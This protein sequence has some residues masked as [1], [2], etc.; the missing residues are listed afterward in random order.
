[1]TTERQLQEGLQTQLQTLE[2]FAAAHVAIND[3]NLMDEGAS[4]RRIVII[5]NTDNFSALQA[6]GDRSFG[7]AVIPATMAVR[8]VDWKVSLDDFRDTR[9]AIVDLFN[10]TGGARSLGLSAV[11]VDSVT[12]GTPVDYVGIQDGGSQLPTW[13]VQQLNF[14][15]TLF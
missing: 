14:N 2:Q 5:A 1:M 15:I 12:A 4:V 8:F 11:S 6:P 10:A 7:T 3:Y 9:Q 13:I